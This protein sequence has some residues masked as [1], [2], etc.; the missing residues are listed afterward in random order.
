MIKSDA[1]IQVKR[2]EGRR[3]FLVKLW[4]REAN[5][6]NTNTSR[7]SQ[8]LQNHRTVLPHILLTS[9]FN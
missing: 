1:Q 5:L 6:L 2:T 4:Q 9:N 8:A 3:S 7:F